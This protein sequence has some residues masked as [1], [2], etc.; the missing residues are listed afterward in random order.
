MPLS[1]SALL[2]RHGFAHAFSGRHDAGIDLDFAAQAAPEVR[3]RAIAHVSGALAAPAARWFQIQQVHG[4]RVVHI[5]S[6]TPEALAAEQADAFWAGP[7][8]HA[9]LAV[10]VADCVPLLLADPHTGNVAAVHAGWRGVAGGIAELAAQAMGATPATL[11]AALGPSIGPCCFEVGDDVA[12]QIV[13]S[14]D[15]SCRAHESPEHAPG[16]AHVDLRRAL[17]VQLSRL[18]V[19]STHIE[20]VG[21]CSVCTPGA[22]HS[23]RRDGQASGRM[24]GVIVAGRS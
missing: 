1:H 20:N 8:T 18:G 12:T 24:V 13:A 15:D 4:T 23:Y 11:L 3:R 21:G 19:Q 10:R 22:W 16:K 2:L 17:H 6:Q 5:E 14:S 9:S 7:H